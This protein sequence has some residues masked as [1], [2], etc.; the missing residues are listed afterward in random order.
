MGIP[1]IDKKVIDELRDENV[2]D[3][4]KGI[5]TD[6]NEVYFVD[7]TYMKSDN[8]RKQ[9]FTGEENRKYLRQ[10]D[11]DEMTDEE[12]NRMQV[13]AKMIEVV[14]NRRKAFGMDFFNEYENR[15]AY[16]DIDNQD[17]GSYTFEDTG[18]DLTGRFVNKNNNEVV[19]AFR[20]LSPS[21]DR[22]DL[23][24]FGSMVRST[25]FE[26]ERAE[27]FGSQYQLDKQLFNEEYRKTKQLYPKHKLITTGHSRGSRGAIHL[28]RKHNL[29]F[30]AFSPVGNRADYVD[31]VPVEGGHLYYNNRDPTSLFIKSQRG[32]TIEQHHSGFN[33]KLNPHSLSDF[34]DDTKILKH[35][36][37][38]K[39][40]IDEFEAELLLDIKS[41][42]EPISGED[43]VD[44]DLGRFDDIT[45]RSKDLVIV[46]SKE[47]A[48]IPRKDV[49]VLPMRNIYTGEIIKYTLGEQENVN[50]ENSFPKYTPSVF[51]DLNLRAQKPFE[52]DYFEQIDS[53]K[54]NEIDYKELFN[55]LK[56]RGYSKQDI[57]EL[58]YTF[59]FNNDGKISRREFYK[60][61]QNL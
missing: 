29:E 41:S 51:S 32:K 48:T 47:V 2:Q 36:K 44:S 16:K 46:P 3:Y 13:M 57:D 58:F 20:G 10:I 12:K 22:K 43:Y 49:M 17:I 34:Y 56:N 59:D 50:F 27:G 26:D 52:P 15:K 35:K 39:K 11:L 18:N 53:D 42:G 24:Q 45:L 38:D 37:L 40:E 14:Y 28:G 6:E 21:V 19:L 8:L 25:I 9:L 31:S 5:D 7:G 60:L 4:K 55:Y 30:H 61:K 1:I 23:K 54:N 33:K